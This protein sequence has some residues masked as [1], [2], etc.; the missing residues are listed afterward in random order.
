MKEQTDDKPQKPKDKKIAVVEIF[1]P[2]FQGEGPLAGSKTMFLRLGGCDYRCTKCDSLHAVLP[3]AV[4]ANSRYLT[5]DEIADEIIALAKP[6]ATPYLTIS[7]GNPC[8][9][10]LSRLCSL[11]NG[12]GINIAVET[13]GTIWQPWLNQCQMVVI[14]PK[15]RGMGEKFEREKFL[16]VVRRVRDG[17]KAAVAIKIVVFAQQDI[18]FALEI[19]DLV[20]EEAPGAVHPGLMFIS[21]GNPWPPVLGEDL[22]LHDNFPTD[23]EYGMPFDHRRELLREYRILMEDIVADPRILFWKFLPQLHVLTYSNESER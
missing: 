14:S 17:K 18:E 23:E 3:E 10:D 13:Q 8:M 6:S 21:L 4:K 1:G 15:G 22:K 2:T 16:N 5:A 20:I 7:G 19:Q 12:A 11:L 9:W